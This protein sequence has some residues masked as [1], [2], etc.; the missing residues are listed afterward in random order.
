MADISAILAWAADY[1]PARANPPPDLS[2]LSS[3]DV[4]A[5]FERCS[6]E[7]AHLALVDRAAI[8]RHLADGPARA[9]AFAAWQRLACSTA[10]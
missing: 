8:R 6:T 2:G 5:L 4:V 7:I 10:E 1:Y 9:A 3:D